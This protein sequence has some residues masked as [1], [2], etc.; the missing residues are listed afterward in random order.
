MTIWMEGPVGQVVKE[1]VNQNVVEVVE[2]KEEEEVVGVGDT[3][4][5]KKMIFFWMNILDLKKRFFEWMF[6]TF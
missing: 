6:W 2:N 4:S 3:A 1:V 5:F